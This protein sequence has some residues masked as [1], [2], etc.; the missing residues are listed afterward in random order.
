MLGKFQ[1]IQEKHKKLP[2]G[3]VDLINYFFLFD[4]F[5]HDCNKFKSF[6]VLPISTNS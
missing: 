3:N 1:K 5:P 4:D 2:S 6:V